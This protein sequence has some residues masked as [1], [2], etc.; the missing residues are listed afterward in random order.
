MSKSYY[1]YSLSNSHMR[2]YAALG[3]GELGIGHWALGR[4][5][6]RSGGMGQRG[7]WA[8]GRM[9]AQGIGRW[10]LLVIITNK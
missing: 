6:K 2:Y 7:Y 8:S 10:L 9:P 1:L 3:M 5:A 4:K